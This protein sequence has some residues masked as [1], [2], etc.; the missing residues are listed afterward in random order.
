MAGA[1]LEVPRACPRARRSLPAGGGDEV[2]GGW[3]DPERARQEWRDAIRSPD[4]PESPTMRWV[5]WMLSTYMKPDGSRC[6][7][8]AERLAEHTGLT[9]RT[10]EEQLRR[11]E[12]DGWVERE[13]SGREGRGW[14]L[15]SYRPALPAGVNRPAPTA[16]ES[17]LE[18]DVRAVFDL[19]RTLRAER[20]GKTSGPRLQLTKKR[21][22]VIRARRREGFTRDYLED[23]ARGFYADDWKDRDK[24]LDPLYA[25]KN[26][27][28]VRRFAEQ[29][30]NGRR[31]PDGAGDLQEAI[32]AMEG[33]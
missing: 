22:S 1:T 4:G 17:E 29:Y 2:D 6:F 26:E 21:A 19:C 18:D 8:G 28:T 13:V 31:A 11:A 15:M 25:F 20:I 27:E 24:Y 9:K 33:E 12:G 16:E 7:V 5:L 32:R 3:N 10:V 14:R 23:C 30:R